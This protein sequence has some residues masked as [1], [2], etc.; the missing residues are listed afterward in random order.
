MGLNSTQKD[1]SSMEKEINSSMDLITNR[2]DSFSMDSISISK[3]LESGPCYS[4]G[5]EEMYK[6]K[7]HWK[8]GIVTSLNPLKVKGEFNWGPKQYEK[9]RKMRG[10]SEVNDCSSNEEEEFTFEDFRNILTSARQDTITGRQ[11]LSMSQQSRSN[12]L[13]TIRSL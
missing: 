7:T 10:N 3:D 13:Q 5:E 1:S 6:S 2:E 8:H 9:V 11:S 4:L 12:L